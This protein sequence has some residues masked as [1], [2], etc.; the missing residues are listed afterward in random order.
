MSA[1]MDP[2][3]DWQGP[4]LW[5][6]VREIREALQLTQQELA[7]LLGVSFAAVNRW[8]NGRHKPQ[9]LV[10][11]RLRELEE[12]MAKGK[13]TFTRR[14]LYALGEACGFRLSGDTEDLDDATVDALEKA[15]QKISDKLAQMD[16]AEQQA[17]E[18]RRAA[19][20]PMDMENPAL[21]DA[22]CDACHAVGMPWTDPRTG[23]TYPPPSKREREE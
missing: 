11:A 14:E 9:R 3:E 22:A 12:R 21:Y 19:K 18:K 10:L 16:R 4:H 1:M 17:I 23:I 15:H 2:P 8:E 6:Y 7:E 20:P 13:A 5:R